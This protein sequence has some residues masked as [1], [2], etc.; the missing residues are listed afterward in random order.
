M[1]LKNRLFWISAFIA[2][3]LDQ[4]TKYW[5]VQTFSLE[6]TLPLLPGI[7]HLTYV[8][9]TGAA[10]SLLSGK[11]EWLRWLSLGV[12]LVLIGLALFGPTLS[13]WDQLG[14]G[15]ILGGAMGNGI[16]RFVLGYVVDFLDF[17]LIN[18]A[19]FNVADSFISIG[20]VCLLIAS[21]QKTPTST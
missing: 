17:R 2:F 4:I 11:V 9:N 6:Q 18:F 10:F 1:R 5:V 12:S 3:F 21:L 14:Y 13:L 19:V 16:D 20:I 7:F 8:T 15:L